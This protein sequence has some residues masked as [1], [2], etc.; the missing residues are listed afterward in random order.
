MPP[1]PQAVANPC[2]TIDSPPGDGTAIIRADGTLVAFGTVPLGVVASMKAFIQNN[3]NVQTGPFAVF[4]NGPGAPPEVPP[5]EGWFALCPTNAHSRK[6]IITA[7]NG[8]QNCNSSVGFNNGPIP[9]P[10]NG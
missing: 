10:A 2:P 3:L 6:F 4:A 1:I 9:N 7:K 8:L 5:G